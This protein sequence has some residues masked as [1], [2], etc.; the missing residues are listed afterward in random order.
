MSVIT[1]FFNTFFLFWFQTFGTSFKLL[2]KRVVAGFLFLHKGYL[3]WFSGFDGGS[4]LKN[5][6]L[7][8]MYTL[9]YSY[10]AT[11]KVDPLCLI[12]AFIQ[13]RPVSGMF[14]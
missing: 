10:F 2:R 9:E 4:K 13:Y 11:T 12:T 7:N 8:G 5:E 1:I 14:Y 6:Q 3:Y